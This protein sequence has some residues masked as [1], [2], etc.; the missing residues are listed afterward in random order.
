[1]LGDRRRVAQDPDAADTRKHAVVTK[2]KANDNYDYPQTELQA[3]TYSMG[4]LIWDIKQ[5][6]GYRKTMMEELKHL[7]P[8]VM[9]SSIPN[10]TAGWLLRNTTERDDE[11]QQMPV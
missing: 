4:K 8:S 3:M 7:R 1:M 9:I 11:K 2:V 5:L 10:C 6:D